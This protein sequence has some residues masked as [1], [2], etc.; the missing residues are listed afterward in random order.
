MSSILLVSFALAA[1]GRVRT[2]GWEH[3]DVDEDAVKKAETFTW[4]AVA[5]SNELDL[6][7]ASNKT[8]EAAARQVVA[9]L[10]LRVVLSAL[11][12]EER[13]AIDALLFRDLQGAYT[14]RSSKVYRFNEPNAW[15]TSSTSEN[16]VPEV[17][18]V[19]WKS[20]A[21]THDLN[22]VE[23]VALAVLDAKVRFSPGL[24]WIAPGYIY[25]LV[26]SGH[27]GEKH[28]VVNVEL[29]K[30]SEGKVTFIQESD[31]SAES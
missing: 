16:S 12:G 28:V 2:G 13:I 25:R 8:V 15:E 11:F 7:V 9:G 3:A 30:S 20:V 31:F 23:G 10:N 29:A 4:T 26:L 17:A 22:L 1:A 6:N 5:D 24:G 19:A 18:A 27:F 21:K 14:L